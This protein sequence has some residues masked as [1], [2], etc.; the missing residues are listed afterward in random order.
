MSIELLSNASATGSSVKLGGGQYLFRAESDN[1]NGA[2]LQ[3][4]I[5]GPNDNWIDVEDATFTADGA[6]RVFL[7]GNITAR[8]EITGS[9]TGVYADLLVFGVGR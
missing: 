7:P 1:W 5:V 8:A 9:P 6:T 4:Q 3:L 2:T